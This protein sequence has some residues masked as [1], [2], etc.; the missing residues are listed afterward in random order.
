MLLVCLDTKREMIHREHKMDS[1]N[2]IEVIDYTKIN[3]LHGLSTRIRL[4]SCW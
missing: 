1:L 4:I 3:V 2:Q